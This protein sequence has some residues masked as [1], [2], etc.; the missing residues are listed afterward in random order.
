M[1]TIIAGFC[2][3][4]GT[5]REHPQTQAILRIF[6]HLW[7]LFWRY[8]LRGVASWL[9]G[10]SEYRGI[11]STHSSLAYSWKQRG[12]PVDT[13]MKNRGCGMSFVRLPRRGSNSNRDTLM[14][15]GPSSRVAMMDTFVHTHTYQWLAS[16][17]Q[18]CQEPPTNR[19]CRL[20]DTDRDVWPERRRNKS[21]PRTASGT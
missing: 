5:G 19:K 3:A 9:A 1:A 2:I 4:G 12:D 8:S 21:N 18:R 17:P 10:D 20:M 6:F 14:Q 16:S 7:T 11:L 15:Q 13:Q